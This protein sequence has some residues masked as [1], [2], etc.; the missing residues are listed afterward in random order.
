MVSDGDKET[1]I[2][3]DYFKVLEKAPIKEYTVTFK[4][5]DG[6]ILKE[7]KVTAGGSATAPNV[8]TFEGYEF[9]DWDREFDN[10]TEDLVV[11][12]V[13]EPVTVNEPGKS[14]CKKDLAVLVVSLISLATM[15]A[16]VLKREK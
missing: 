1:E 4:D 13:Y 11:T 6:N 10:I 2:Y 12:A 7:E 16:V 3:T 15:A 8:P 14:G 9:L 5:K